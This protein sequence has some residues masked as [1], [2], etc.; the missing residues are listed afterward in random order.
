M[1]YTSTKSFCGALSDG[2]GDG[3]DD[4]VE[5]MDRTMGEGKKE[6]NGDYLQASDIYSCPNVRLFDFGEKFERKIEGR[7]KDSW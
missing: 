7:H 4:L 3:H 6:G 5:C 1:F 2:H